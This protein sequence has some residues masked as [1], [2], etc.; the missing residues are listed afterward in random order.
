M[1]EEQGL[2]IRKLREQGMGYRAIASAVN[3]SRDSV[4]NYCRS[5]GLAGY[6]IE[7]EM[8]LHDRMQEGR[9]CAFCGAELIKESTGRPKRFCSDL[10]RR[11]YWKIHRSE[12]KKKPTAIYT[13]ECP[14]CHE[15]FEAYGNKKRKYCCHEHYILDRFGPKE[16]RAVPKNGAA[17]LVPEKEQ[18]DGV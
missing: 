12:M 1:T 6:R 15:I 14:Y 3:L 7:Y 11:N 16:R 8:N 2:Q 13:L 18:E 10:C 9:A 5:R 4:R 17:F